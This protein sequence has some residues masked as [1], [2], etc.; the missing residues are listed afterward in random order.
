MS[1]VKTYG[2]SHVALSVRDPQRS[3]AFYRRILGVVAVYEQDDFVQAQKPGTWDVLV[4]EKG[5]RRADAGNGIKHFGFRLQKPEDM[6][7]ALT[8]ITAAARPLAGL[9]QAA[10]HAATR[11]AVA[12]APEN[13]KRTQVGA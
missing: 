10:C 8:A 5:A 4:F 1:P 7:S 9:D 11:F 2:L 13:A 6:A 12:V 3:L